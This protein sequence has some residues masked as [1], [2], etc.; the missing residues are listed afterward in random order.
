MPEDTNPLTDS[1]TIEGSKPEGI[2][3]KENRREIKLSDIPRK[4]ETAGNVPA[5]LPQFPRVTQL[6]FQRR[7]RRPRRHFGPFTGFCYNC[8]FQGHRQEQCSQNNLSK[9]PLKRKVTPNSVI[10]TTL[11]STIFNFLK[12]EDTNHQ[13]LRSQN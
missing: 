5:Y 1:P 12:A 8:G 6:P 4:S 7:Y 3:K 11:A 2:V 10:E 9:Y 13:S